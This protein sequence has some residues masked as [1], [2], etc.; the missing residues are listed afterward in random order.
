MAGPVPLSRKK[1]RERVKVIHDKTKSIGW[2]EGC[3]ERRLALGKGSNHCRMC[4]RKLVGAKGADGK[5]LTWMQKKNACNNS[6][7]GCPKCDE[8]ICKACWTEGCDMHSKNKK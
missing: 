5:P 2:T 3:S 8:P 4:A 6:T 7:M 1:G